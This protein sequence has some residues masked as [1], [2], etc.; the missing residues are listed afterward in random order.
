MKNKII[1][2][3]VISMLILSIGIISNAA[4]T[5]T[6]LN[7]KNSFEGEQIQQLIVPI[8]ITDTTGTVESAIGYQATLDYDESVFESVT[9][10]AQNGWNATYNDTTKK[11]VQDT[12]TAKQNQEVG[13]LTFTLKSYTKDVSTTI[14]ITGIKIATDTEFVT[15]ADKSVSVKV[16]AEEAK[17]DNTVD[18]VVGNNITLN[19]TNNT[20]GNKVSVTGNNIDTTTA[21]NI[22]PATGIG[23]VLLIM[24]VICIISA[25]FFRFKAR[26]IK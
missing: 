11:I 21:K 7:V 20:S 10:T 12:T 22:L 25:V 26:K 1:S 4:V 14:K 18:N 23:R 6:D 13:K 8:Y 5:T 2:I 15:P 19:T 3:L 24:L 16:K 17:E 9:L